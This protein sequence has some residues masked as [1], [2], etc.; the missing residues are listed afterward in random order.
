MPGCSTC[1]SKTVCTSCDSDYYS[2][3]FGNNTRC[4]PLD[5]GCETKDASGCIKCKPGSY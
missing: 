5:K 1:S 4:L 3:N 2:Y